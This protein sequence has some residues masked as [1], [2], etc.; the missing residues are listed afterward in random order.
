[1]LYKLGRGRVGRK[2]KY[3]NFGALNYTKLIY[4]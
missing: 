2:K 3:S 4:P 1:M